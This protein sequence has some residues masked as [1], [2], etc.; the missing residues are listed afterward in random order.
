MLLQ[1]APPHQ[2]ETMHNHLPI[3]ILP[4]DGQ[5]VYYGPVM[6]DSQ[7]S[8]AFKNLYE[9]IEWQQ[10]KGIMFGRPYVT[11]RKT[12]WY[13]D[14]PYAY[15][16]S[17][18]TRTAL[19]WTKVLKMLKQIVEEISAAPY[20]SCL[21]NFYHDGNDSMGWHSDDEKEIVS[22]SAIASLSLGAERRFV[23]RHKTSRQKHEISL[24]NGSVLVMEGACQTHWQHTLPAMRRVTQP[25][26]NLTFRLMA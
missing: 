21:L 17:S 16:Y 7:A 14:H 20:N 5:A 18:V 22:N 1:P 15:T 12:A 13:G 3:N 24:Q 26:I 10:D 2:T 8:K 19:P 6:T 23:L 4:H 25:R 9:T 11:R